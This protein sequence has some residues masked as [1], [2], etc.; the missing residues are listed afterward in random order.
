MSFRSQLKNTAA[1]RQSEYVTPGQYLFEILD[2]K[3][4]ENRKGRSFVVVEMQVL[5]SDDTNRHPRG[6]ERSYLQM[7]DTDTAAK[8]VRGFLTRA[9]NVPDEGLTDEMIDKAFEPLEETGKSPLAG[10]KIGVNARNIVTRKG[11]DFTVVDFYSVDQDM[12]SLED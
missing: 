4:G 11:S 10:L 5:D 8:N 7:T 9:L 2:F 1:R 3:E 6:S 12:E